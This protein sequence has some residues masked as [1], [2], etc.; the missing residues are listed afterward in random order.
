MKKQFFGIICLMMI[1]VMAD[2]QGAFR[3]GVKAGANLNKIDGQ[4]FN[5]AFDYA[6]HAGAFAELDFTKTFGL[7]PEV[8]LSQTSVTR[9][10]NVTSLYATLPTDIKLNYLEIPVL[11]RL[12]MSRF[13]TFNAG[14]QFGILMSGNKS[15]TQNGVNAFKNGALSAVAGVQ[16]NILSFRVYGRYNIGLQEIND[17]SNPEK[18][19]SQQI[20]LGLAMKF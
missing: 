2:A 7:Q 5:Q 1:G 18:W 16:L 8:L 12:N 17:V 4:T 10:T 9:A 3:L 14:P 15:L 11:L 13:L 20:Q 6:Y 19:K